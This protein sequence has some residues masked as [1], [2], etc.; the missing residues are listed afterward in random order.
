[1]PIDDINQSGVISSDDQQEVFQLLEKLSHGVPSLIDIQKLD[2][3]K[4]NNNYKDII[5]SNNQILDNLCTAAKNN[6][7]CAITLIR[8]GMIIDD[9]RVLDIIMGVDDPDGLLDEMD[10]QNDLSD[11]I[12]HYF[13][14]ALDES[15]FA[16]LFFNSALATFFTAAAIKPILN[17]HPTLVADYV[18]KHINTNNI[19]RLSD[20]VFN[21][22]LMMDDAVQDFFKRDGQA[23]LVS[24]AA[25]I[26]SQ[27]SRIILLIMKSIFNHS[28]S[29]ASKIS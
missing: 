28:S 24:L 23:P 27:A 26:W 1:M 10:K 22:D 12:T 15:D 4:S 6:F 16:K 8:Q 9:K 5:N 29:L 20:V 19:D 21:D 3:I 17:A 11:L 25:Y 18:I 13:N 14:R 2:S 7:E